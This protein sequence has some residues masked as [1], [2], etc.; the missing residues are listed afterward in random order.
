MKKTKTKQEKCVKNNT[1]IYTCSNA[2]NCYISRVKSR[3][4]ETKQKETLYPL[5]YLSSSR[6]QKWKEKKN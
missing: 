1:C 6:N 5:L 3:K 4:N 2:T